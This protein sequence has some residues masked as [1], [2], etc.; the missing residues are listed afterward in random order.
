[1]RVVRC[2]CPLRALRLG[3]WPLDTLDA[4]K[5]QVYGLRQPVRDGMHASRIAPAELALTAK[6]RIH[7]TGE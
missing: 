7:H 2:V 3:G 6:G 1:M 4:F 5:Q